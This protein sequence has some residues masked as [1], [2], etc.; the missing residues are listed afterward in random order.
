[1]S[2]QLV[3]VNVECV[4]L[5]VVVEDDD[6]FVLF[7]F[8]PFYNFTV[9]GLSS[10]AYSCENNLFYRSPTIFLDDDGRYFFSY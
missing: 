10:Y 2:L 6:V 3:A 9:C 5:L 4:L 1:M 7:V 8:T